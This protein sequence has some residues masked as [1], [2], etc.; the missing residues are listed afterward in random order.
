MTLEG[1]TVLVT[2]ASG[3][4]GG[5][6]V[7]RLL[8]EEKARPRALVRQ[9]NHASWLSRISADMI[10]GDVTDLTSLDRAAQGCDV[11]FH[12]AASM[13]GD[14]ETMERVNV[15]GTQN[16]LEVAKR[17]GVSR[18]VHVSSLAVHGRRYRDGL[19][20]DDPLVGDEDPYAQTKLAAEQ[21]VA[22]AV[23]AH[24]L[25]AVI[26][27]P[28]IVYGPRSQW[29]TVDPINRIKKNKL[30]LLGRGDGVANVV[31]IDDVVTSLLLAATAPDLVGEAFI[32]S[33]EE[34]VTWEDFFGAYARM[35]GRTLPSWPVGFARMVTS[36][37]DS[38]NRSIEGMHRSQMRGLRVGAVVSLRGLR[39]MIQPLYKLNGQEVAMYGPRAQISVEKAKHRLGY[40]SQWPL[41]RAM[42]ETEI[43]LHAQG[44]LP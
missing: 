43:W 40:R 42:Q 4:V 32:I 36:V 17:A 22:R 10:P 34:R 11:I 44:Y 15:A 31:Y 24:T 7:E 20:E 16:V 25:P 19:S 39:K 2:G 30:A 8:I 1:K 28:S 41:S 18:L 13:G 33:S 6:L 29:W 23:E 27:R 37:T 9:F 12:C 3:F 14:R 35:V 21:L 38:L 5:R 26:V